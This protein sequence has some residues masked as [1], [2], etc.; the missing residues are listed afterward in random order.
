MALALL[1]PL[2]IWLLLCNLALWTGLVET[3]VTHD[4]KLTSLKL[5]H[6]FAWTIWPTRVHVR[7]ATFSIDGY[8]YQLGLEVDEALVDMRLV[9]LF[10]HRVRFDSIEATGVR[11][12][13]R[14]KI[15]PDQADAP[16]LAAYAAFD[17]TPP[18]VRATEPKP[19]P[20][21]E[22]AWGV[23][24]DDITAQVDSL[25]VNEFDVEPCGHIRGEMHWTDGADFSVPTTTVEL[26]DAVLWLG[27]REA[28]RGIAGE[29]HVAI[30][31][32][33]TSDPTPHKVPS[34]LSF[35]FRADA[36]LVDPGSFAVWSPKIE[37]QV[38]AAPG[39]LEIDVSAVDGVLEQGSRVHHSSDAVWFGPER[40][41]LH[42]AVEL[43]LSVGEHGKPGAEAWLRKASVQGHAHGKSVGELARTRELHARVVVPHGDMAKP[44][45]IES[46]SAETEEVVADDLRRLSA[47]IGSDD[48]Q[49]LRGSAR[50]HA[51]AQMGSDGQPSGRFDLHVDELA[52]ATGPVE[53]RADLDSSGRVRTE[54]KGGLRADELVLRSP[55]ITVRSPFGTSEGTWVKLHDGSV[56]YH[57]QEIVVETRGR[58]EDARPAIVHLTKLDP[59]L[60]VV[61]DLQKQ[62]PIEVHSKLA[63]R[64]NLIELD[65]VDIEH[66]GVHVGAL[67]RKR[68][69]SWRLALLAS[70]LTAFGFTIDDD[71]KVGTLVPLVGKPWFRDQRRWVQQLG[72]RK[73]AAK[74]H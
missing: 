24:L 42:G 52:L 44:W 30:A 48:V 65:L 32:F 29:L 18:Q 38:G 22:D 57:E 55:G 10:D 14:V 72:P 54:P 9:S 21:A 56:H 69:P 74:Q 26:A 60:D 15:R 19:V 4:G 6:G 68:G 40:S 58:I 28:V 27:G 71:H 11:A 62:V 33:D 7:N 2:P 61:P 47:V 59:L 1:L 5:S 12:E 3:L 64:G 16:Q 39:P 35:G 51:S 31:P 25:W 70:G 46:A 53:I 63:V 23:D 13:Y 66:L 8:T 50:A 73:P 34:H 20:S 41:R 36:E 43:V 67:W 37:G 49:L 17:G 45:S